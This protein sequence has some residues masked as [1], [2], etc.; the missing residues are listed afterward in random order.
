MLERLW[1][2]NFEYR[3]K[4]ASP[5]TSTWIHPRSGDTYNLKLIKAGDLTKEELEACFALVAETSQPDYEGSSLGWHPSKKRKE[6]RSPDLKY[7]L[8]KDTAGSLRGFTS[9]MPTM[10]E[11]EPVVYCYEIHLKP[12]LRG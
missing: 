5:W 1:R 7:V 4:D 12:E 3:A 10:E 6:M 8:V 9:F 2:L 11:G